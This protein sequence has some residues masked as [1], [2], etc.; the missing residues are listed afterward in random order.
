MWVKKF[1]TKL[2]DNDIK[3]CLQ[4]VLDVKLNILFTWINIMLNTKNIFANKK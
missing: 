2:K 3:M 4:P 1:L